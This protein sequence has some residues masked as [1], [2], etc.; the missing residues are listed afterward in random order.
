[1]M[2]HVY[3][4]VYVPWRVRYNRNPHGWV[5]RVMPRRNRESEPEVMIKFARSLWYG[6]N[7][8]MFDQ[9]FCLEGGDSET[10]TFEEFYEY[11]VS[12]ELPEG[13]FTDYRSEGRKHYEERRQRIES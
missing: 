8:D 7:M 5:T 12:S 10:L 4:H 1:M 3:D 11:K 13:T 2:P 9:E 6:R